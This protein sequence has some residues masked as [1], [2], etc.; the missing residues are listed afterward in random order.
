MK[1]DTRYTSIDVCPKTGDIVDPYFNDGVCPSCGHKQSSISHHDQIPGRWNRPNLFER[2][3]HG[4]KTVFFTKEDEDKV[5]GPLT[6]KGS[7]K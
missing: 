4:K 5:W 6:E 7:N 3:I 1:L 2:I